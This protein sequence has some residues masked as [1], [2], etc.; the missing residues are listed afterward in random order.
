MTL[1]KEELF[2]KYEEMSPFGKAFFLNKAEKYEELQNEKKEVLDEMYRNG[3]NHQV[4]VIIE[5]IA[6]VE[7]YSNSDFPHAPF[8]MSLKNKETG[9]WRHSSH[10]FGSVDEAI[11]GA[12]GHKYLGQNSQFADFASKMLGIKEMVVV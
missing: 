8:T 3:A 7:N 4:V 1:T 12:M 9:K 11:L 5:D 6:I 10:Y 2:A